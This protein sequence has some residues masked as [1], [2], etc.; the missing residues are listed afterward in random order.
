MSGEIL[1]FSLKTKEWIKKSAMSMPRAYHAS[2]SLGTKVYFIGGRDF[3]QNKLKSIEWY[4]FTDGK[5]GKLSDEELNK[6]F[7]SPREQPAAVALTGSKILV[8]GGIDR[9]GFKRGDAII[10]DDASQ[11]AKL[12]LRNPE[13]EEKKGDAEQS[14]DEQMDDTCKKY[15]VEDKGI[16]EA[17]P[18]YDQI[19]VS[20]IRF[21]CKSQ[22]VLCSR[23]Q[24]DDEERKEGEEDEVAQYENSVI[25][26]VKPEGYGSCFIRFQQGDGKEGS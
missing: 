4:N 11:T 16:K 20:N 8:M 26:L 18:N 1:F 15:L 22:T 17:I 6:A 14:E 3:N 23:V 19:P 25:S 21:S 13:E 24:D 7:F 5:K 9:Y 2:C 10:I 12:V